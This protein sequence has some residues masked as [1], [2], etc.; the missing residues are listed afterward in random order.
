M[1]EESFKS[2]L[3]MRWPGV[4]KPQTRISELVQNIDLAPTLI[5]AAGLPIPTSVHGL[6]LQPILSG[7]KTKSWRK[8]LLY[9]YFDG[10]TPENR[11]PYNMPR[12]EGVRDTRYKL[13]SFYEYGQWELY[14]LQTDPHEVNNLIQAPNM[15]PQIKRLKKRLAELKKGYG[16]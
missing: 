11:G 16:L 14:D 2:P 13:I 8:D 9:Q 15:K 6:P 1:Y 12:H 10:G 5:E 4:I 7:K 3:L